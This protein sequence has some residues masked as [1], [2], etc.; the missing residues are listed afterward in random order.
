M[1]IAVS[2]GD[3]K[4]NVHGITDKVLN[5]TGFWKYAAT[6]W[7]RLYKD[8]VPMKNGIL[9][10]RV[11]ITPKQIEHTA[12]YAHYQYEGRAYGPNYP[13]TEGK[14]AVGFFSQPNQTKKPTGKALNYI[15]DQHPKAC[16]HWDKAAA[17]TQ[18]PKLVQAMQLYIDSGRLKLE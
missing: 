4:I 16:A 7:H 13:N 18:T 5:D 15:K 3:I 14:R 11:T 17:P 12:P 2:V 9:Y 10:N 6:E 1:K 8:Y